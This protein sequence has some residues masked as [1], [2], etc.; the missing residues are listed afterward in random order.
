MQSQLSRRRFTIVGK[1]FMTLLTLFVLLGGIGACADG[2]DPSYAPDGPYLHEVIKPASTRQHEAYAILLCRVADVATMPVSVDAVKKLFLKDGQGTGNIYD[3]FLNVSYGSIDLDGSQVYTG[4]TASGWYT[5]KSTKADLDKRYNGAPVQRDQTEN[6][7]VQAAAD[8][9]GFKRSDWAGIVAIINIPTDSGNENS[10]GVVVGYPT[11]PG[12]TP[13]Y[14]PSFIEH[15]MGHALTLSHSM[16]MNMDTSPVHAWSPG[17]DT[18]YD[19]CWDIMSALGCVYGYNAAPYGVSGP[20]LEAA[21]REQLHWM[22]RERIYT[23]PGKG[24][25]TIILAPV[26][27]PRIGGIL[28]A[29]VAAPGLGVYTVE[30]RR[31]SD[32]DQ[33]I[34]HDTVLIHEQRASTLPGEAGSIRTFLVRR[35]TGTSGVLVSAKSNPPLGATW[36][37]GQVFQD[38]FNKV[39]ISID[40]FS[41]PN[42]AITISD[43]MSTPPGPGAGGD[44][45]CDPS[46]AP[47]V[48]ITSPTLTSPTTRLRS[49]GSPITFAATVSNPLGDAL[50]DSHVVW[51]SYSAATDWTKLGTGRTFSTTLKPGTYTLKVTA[52]NSV[53]LQA[54]QRFYLLVCDE[55][56]C[57]PRAFINRPADKTHVRAGVAFTVAGSV[58]NPEGEDIAPDQVVWTANSTRLGLGPTLTTSIA[59]PGTYT[60]TM[61]ATNPLGYKGSAA[62][63][64]IVD[65]PLP[66][67]AV[68]ITA[69]V[70][71]TLYRDVTS[72]GQTVTLQADGSSGVN[73]FDWSD[74]IPPDPTQKSL[75]SGQT[76]MVT[77]YPASAANCALTTHAITL[78]GTRD[79][80]QK[81]TAHV[82]VTLRATCIS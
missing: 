80:G 31:K 48:T 71:G 35:L 30:Y 65:P 12:G 43:D 50:P 15:E 56:T 7:C 58:V 49:D 64:L 63:T 25:A 26:N 32:W 20:E 38:T 40:S 6:D 47:S 37:P 44:N 76:L 73:R 77:L 68:S 45:N 60:L 42:A 81:A 18:E 11:D 69:P 19:D 59:A 55:A 67:P 21:Y 57:A 36:L 9:D 23:Y 3:Y 39:R 52:T 29:K 27:A 16:G 22:P 17:G 28:L 53:E 66:A 75:G 14:V 74:S 8:K 10:N 51:S 13:T 34:P 61:T 54:E 70:D 82:S 4:T 79:D 62:I 46:C 33:G 72:A 41:G 2:P 1:L 5:M 24:T 78:T